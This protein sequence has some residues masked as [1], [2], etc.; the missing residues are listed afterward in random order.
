MRTLCVAALAAAFAIT[1]LP[2]AG[3]GL[4]AAAAKEKERRKAVKGK[5]YTEADLGR[6]G[7]GNYN[8]PQGAPAPHASIHFCAAGASPCPVTTQPFVQPIISM[9]PASVA[10]SRGT[11]ESQLSMQKSAAGSAA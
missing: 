8:A 3:Q 6:T 4:A 9:T 5:T 11:A 1:S 2:A 7:G 10:A